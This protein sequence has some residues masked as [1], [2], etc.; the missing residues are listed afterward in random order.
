MLPNVRHQFDLFQIILEILRLNRILEHFH[1][2]CHPVALTPVTEC[3]LALSKPFILVWVIMSKFS[4]EA[5][6]WKRTIVWPWKLTNF[7]FIRRYLELL[8]K[9][10]WIHI[11]QPVAV[12]CCQGHC[13]VAIFYALCTIIAP[14][15][16]RVVT[17]AA[18]CSACSVAKSKLV[19][20]R[21][22]QPLRQGLERK[23]AKISN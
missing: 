13:G 6:R 8:G 23:W 18:L 1:R 10:E 19:D 22:C 14:T 17:V 16:C 4:N 7:K 2:H 5:T 15:H 9:T 12:Q 11:Q 21:R 3:E 20:F